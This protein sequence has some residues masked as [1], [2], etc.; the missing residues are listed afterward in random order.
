MTLRC[1]QRRQKYVV[2]VPGMR[3]RSVPGGHSVQEVWGGVEME[4]MG[5]GVHWRELGRLE[6]EVEG[7]G[8]QV[9]DPGG[10]NVPAGQV[11]HDVA[12]EEEK[13][14]GGHAVHED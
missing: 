12:R 3:T 8:V 5:H 7:Q 4:L 9:E 14:E 2:A 10:R 6:K 11:V 1:T 13:V